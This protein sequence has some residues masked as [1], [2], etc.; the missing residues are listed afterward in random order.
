VV[1]CFSAQ[2]TSSSLKVELRMLVFIFNKGERGIPWREL[3][4]GSVASFA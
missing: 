3:R 2:S 1:G 4:G